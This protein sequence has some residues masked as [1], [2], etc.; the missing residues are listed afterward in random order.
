MFS[1]CYN[2]TCK[3]SETLDFSIY[4]LVVGHK[5][6]HVYCHSCGTLN[7]LYSVVYEIAGW[8]RMCHSY[9]ETFFFFFGIEI[10]TLSNPHPV[11]AVTVPFRHVSSWYIACIFIIFFLLRFY[12]HFIPSRHRLTFL[13]HTKFYQ[14]IDHHTQPYSTFDLRMFHVTF[15]NIH[16]HYQCLQQIEWQI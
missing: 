5:S 1:S 3:F 9:D 2:R 13:H 8:L 16:Q 7:Y 4:R 11:A 15:Q 6:C 14:I 12:S 10:F